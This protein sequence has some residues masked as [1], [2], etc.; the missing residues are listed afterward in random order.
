LIK[1]PDAYA[2]ERDV[3]HISPHSVR[4][5]NDFPHILAAERTD[6]WPDGPPVGGGE[7]GEQFRAIMAR[8]Q[9]LR[10]SRVPSHR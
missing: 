1:I 7:T 8:A 3:T 10:R 4:S 6:P 9:R 2:Q 5:G